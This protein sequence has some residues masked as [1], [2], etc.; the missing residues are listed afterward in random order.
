MAIKI[1]ALILF[2]VA[3]LT[4]YSIFA[5]AME[6][7]DEKENQTYKQTLGTKLRIRSIQAAFLW[8][9]FIACILFS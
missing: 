2:F 5:I 4:S 8:T 9:G 1:I 6:M 3:F 7:I